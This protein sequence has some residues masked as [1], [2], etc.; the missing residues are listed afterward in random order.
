VG[1]ATGISS[2]HSAVALS[3]G[4]FQKIADIVDCRRVTVLRHAMAT[5]PPMRW[6][7]PC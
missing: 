5:S 3:F 7:A 1:R 4:T 6:L 2:D